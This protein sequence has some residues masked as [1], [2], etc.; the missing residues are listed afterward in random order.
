MEK[1]LLRP[2]EVA[3][4]L[5]LGRSKTYQ[6]LANGQLP[7]VRIG[8]SLRVPA[9]ALEDWVQNKTSTLDQQNPPE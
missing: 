2:A 5:G 3:E 4:M 6:M 1:L 7:S 9:Q 8:G